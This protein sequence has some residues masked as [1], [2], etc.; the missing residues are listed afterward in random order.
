MTWTEARSQYPEKWLLIEALKA[1]TEENRRIVEDMAVIK[2]FEDSLE[3]M[4]FY[5][6]YRRSATQRELLV[7]HTRKSE[8]QVEV[9]HCLKNYYRSPKH[10]L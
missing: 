4:R 1:H 6:E 2:Q 8:L 9:R 5:C 7:V 10:L 3:A